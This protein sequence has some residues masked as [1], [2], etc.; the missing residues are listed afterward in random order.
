[1]GKVAKLREKV[2]KLREKVAK[3]E[4]L[5]L[6]PAS[7]WVRIQTS[8]IINLDHKKRSGQWSHI[9]NRFTYF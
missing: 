7:S 6:V 4:A 3:L 8:K 5:L 9:F 2:A 1:M